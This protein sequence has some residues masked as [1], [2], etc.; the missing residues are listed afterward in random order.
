M[1][2]A[3]ISDV[4][5]NLQAFQAALKAI[6]DL[7]IKKIKC[8]GDVVGYNANPCEC[9]KLVQDRKIKTVQGNHD[10]YAGYGSYE[11]RDLSRD[12]FDGLRYSSTLLSE[13]DKEWLI[14]MPHTYKIENKRCRFM[15]CHGSPFGDF[16]YILGQWMRESAFRHLRMTLGIHLCFFGHTH[17]PAFYV[18]REDDSDSFHGTKLVTDTTVS[19]AE[20]QLVEY[21]VAGRELDVSGAFDG[22][23]YYLI[24]PGSIGQPRGC[25]NSFAVLDTEAKTVRYHVFDYDIA[26][27]QKAIRDADYSEAIAIRLDK[28]RGY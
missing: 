13:D 14:K 19:A 20:K 25:P 16:E 6:E 8:L 4:H 15:L 24:N 3:I 18:A 11:L 27:A 23:R 28:G 2:Y 7:G 9:I 17:I 5:S 22:S 21:A 12:A 1:K 10:A 26:A